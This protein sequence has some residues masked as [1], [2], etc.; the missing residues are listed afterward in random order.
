MGDMSKSI[1]PLVIDPSFILWG[2]KFMQHISKLPYVVR[3]LNTG[4]HLIWPKY[5]HSKSYVD[6][7]ICWF[8]VLQ[9]LFEG[10]SCLNYHLQIYAARFHTTL[11]GRLLR[12]L[13]LFQLGLDVNTQSHTL[14]PIHPN[15]WFS[16]FGLRKASIL[17]I[18]LIRIFFCHINC[19]SI[20]S[21]S[22][23]TMTTGKCAFETIFAAS[24]SCR[25][26]IC[27]T[28]TSNDF[29]QFRRGRWKIC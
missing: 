3:W 28:I 18:S 1:Q 9:I 14:T 27:G 17:I 7:L 5:Q 12:A 29:K 26:A 20:C 6:V 15:S 10:S 25:S 2:D 11:W 23:L 21:W 13:V 8:S 16:V 4:L 22:A 19:T 24:T